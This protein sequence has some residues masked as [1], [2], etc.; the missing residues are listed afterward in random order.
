M[1]DG[2]LEIDF[3]SLVDVRI[4]EFG[5]SDS[6]KA[7]GRADEG[8]VGDKAAVSGVVPNNNDKQT[9]TPIPEKRSKRVG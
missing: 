9:H 7:N 3:S 2:S 5:N 1:E 4:I 6:A 8:P